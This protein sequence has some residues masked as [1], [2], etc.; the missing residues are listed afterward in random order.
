MI[1][2]A[3][4]LVALYGAILFIVLI[5]PLTTLLRFL[6]PKTFLDAYFCSPYFG[7]FEKKLY[8]GI[9]YYI[10][11][12]WMFNWAVVFPSRVRSRGISNIREGC[13]D[14]FIWVN[15]IFMG[16]FIVNGVGAI[17]IMLGLIL[18]AWLFK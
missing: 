1:F 11:R 10:M 5:V 4:F 13:P 2:D 18:Y 15:R 16:W 6:T 3:L 12:T 14:W 9:P 7:E 8:T 17:L